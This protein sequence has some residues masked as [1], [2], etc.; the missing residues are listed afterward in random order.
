MNKW[1][2]I[3]NMV[4]PVRTLVTRVLGVGGLY[5]LGSLGCG[6]FTHWFPGGA[7]TFYPTCPRWLGLYQNRV[8]R[9]REPIKRSW[10]GGGPLPLVPLVVGLLDFTL[11]PVAD[12]T[13]VLVADFTPVPVADFTPVLVITH[14]LTIVLPPIYSLRNL[15]NVDLTR[16]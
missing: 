15:K 10:W 11:A 12:F 7:G 16:L 8:S 1:P 6:T 2:E 13:P 4:S 14:I 5:P 9:W 3:K